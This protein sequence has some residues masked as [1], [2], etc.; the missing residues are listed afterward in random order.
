MW[1]GAIL[2]LALPLV[3]SAWGADPPSP[4]R[5]IA[6]LHPSGGSKVSG[7]VMFTDKGN[8]KIEVTGEVTG[9]KPGPHGFHIHEFG[10]CSSPDAMS[11]GPHFNPDNQPHGGPESPQHHV[12]D[13]GNINADENGR[14]VI[15]MTTTKTLALGGTHSIIG[16]GL[17]VHA[18]PDDLKS[19]PAG[20]AGARLACGVI[21]IANPNPTPPK[22]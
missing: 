18:D 2:T 15:R 12:G 20:N 16:R 13:L 9:L 7:V 11:T 14:A 3:T 17:I 21:G 5:A 6:V 22:K 8:G 1:I 10:D 4:N 19:Q